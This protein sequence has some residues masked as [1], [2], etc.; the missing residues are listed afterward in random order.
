M[1]D[2]PRQLAAVARCR[3]R[4]DRIRMHVIDMRPIYQAMQWRVDA[5]RARIEVEGAVRI[6]THHA[7]LILRTAVARSQRQ[8]LLEVER[9]ETIE[10]HG[11]E[12]TA[13]ALDPQH[14]DRTPGERIGHEQLGGGIAAAEIGHALVGAQQMRS[15]EEQLLRAHGRGL[16]V[17][18]T[19]SRSASQSDSLCARSW[20]GLLS[21]TL[22][23][24]Q[25][26]SIIIAKLTATL[27]LGAC[28]MLEAE[29]RRMIL[30]LLQE[31]SVV[32]VLQLVEMFS[33]SEAT[34]RRD[35]AALADEGKLTRVWGGAESLMPRHETYLAGRPFEMSLGIAA[36]QKSAIARAAAALIEEGESIIING[37]TTTFALVEHLAD[38]Q[39]DILTNSLPIVTKLMANSRSR[40]TVPGGTVYRE[41]NIVLSP[42]DNDA[43]GHFWGHKLFTGCYGLNRFG[44]METDPLLVQA[45]LKLLGRAE[46]ILVLADS[47]KLRQRSSMIVAGLERIRTFIT[48][49]GATEEELEPLRNAGIQVITVETQASDDAREHSH[50]TPL[51]SRSP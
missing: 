12:V 46:Q 43:I 47:R 27:A 48:D 2:L 44:L 20:I 42:Y 16:F 31:R 51:R 45:E 25:A 18:P 40:V 32:S 41:Q 21:H 6:E 29:R 4:D 8:E 36:A 3:D 37:G 5:R 35:I 10:T 7:V 9:R 1:P 15:I 28:T 50:P 39:L 13:G 38:R 49:T 26:F 11:A 23:H 24:C 30:K 33:V 34:A 19:G 17:I 22:F 14:L